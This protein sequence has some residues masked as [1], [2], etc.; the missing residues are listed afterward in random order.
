VTGTTATFNA[1]A[2]VPGFT[3]VVTPATLT[4]APG[5]S[6]NFTVK[7]TTT[8]ATEGV[9]QYGQLVWSDGT[10]SVR[11]PI[12]AKVGKPI[13]V[14]AADFTGTTTSG[15]RLFTVKTGFAGRMG[16]KVGGM[17]DVTMSPPA[18][19]AP[20]AT[21]SAQLKTAC[22]AG[23]DTAS[24]KVYNFTVPANAIVARF[25]LRQADTSA[26]TDD[27]D[28]M[29]LYPD[30]NTSLYSGND[31]SNESVQIL[32]PAAGT[33]KVCVVA[34]G[35]ATGVTSMTHSLS[36]W[37]VAAGDGAG[38]R[39]LTPQAVYS[40]GTA[41]VGLSWSGLASGKRY[42]GGIQYLD[43]AGNVQATSAVRVSTDGAVPVQNEPA[44][45]PRKLVAA[46]AE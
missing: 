2:N 5:A 10:R 26:A 36:S 12:Q 25:A 33:Y 18:T 3:T 38:L 34:Y 15:S 31:G 29:V 9:W 37:I 41:T 32:S 16:S 1:T 28:L 11:S 43:A 20:Q 30:N 27:N 40:G 23:V 35:G 6:A 44:S 22:Q 4:L 13:S 46:A 45:N 21:T 17:K 39:V 24:V 19:L 14:P 8:T 42:V 7:L